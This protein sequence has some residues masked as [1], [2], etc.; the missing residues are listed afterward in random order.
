MTI[1][2]R[3]NK[4]CFFSLIL[5]GYLLSFTSCSTKDSLPVLTTTKVS[6]ITGNSAKAGG[7]ITSDGSADI[8]ARGVC[9]SKTAYPTL[10]DRITSD[11]IGGG[12]FTSSIAGLDTATTYYVRAY[13][14]SSVGTAYGNQVSFKTVGATVT[15]I[16][17]NV[18]HAITIGTQVWMA[19]NLKT[20]RYRSGESISNVT[21]SLAWSKATFGAWCNYNNDPANGTT[22]GRLYNWAAIS[23][24]RNITPAGWHIATQAEWTT[25]ITYLGGESVAAG[26]LKETGF[27]HWK[28]SPTGG[29]T[30]GSGFTALPGGVRDP[31]GAFGSIGEN[32]YWWSTTVNS[33]TTPSTVWF[34]YMSFDNSN[35]HK[36]Y[37]STLYGRSVRCV[38]DSD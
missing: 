23:D 7:I 20:T 19:E 22:Y 24:V 26:K 32:G 34:W 13:A 29:A 38:K 2:K 1:M 28:S 9:W 33:T 6:S 16:D 25:L 15:D 35:A 17:G 14:T 36:D 31:S 8:T 30:N 5:L 3:N 37:E 27:V 12:S 11:S 4:I 21:D 10:A 18:Y